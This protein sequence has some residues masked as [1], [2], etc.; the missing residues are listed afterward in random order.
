MPQVKFLRGEYNNLK[1]VPLSDGTIYFTED[2]RRLYIDTATARL[3]VAGDTIC[4]KVF[5]VLL[6]KNAWSNSKQIITKYYETKD[7]DSDNLSEILTDESIIF[8]GHSTFGTSSEEGIYPA[9]I[10]T[11]SN[12]ESITFQLYQVPATEEGTSITT[13]IPKEDIWIQIYC[14]NPLIK[15]F[16]KIEVFRTVYTTRLYLKANW[17]EPYLDTNKYYQ[18]IHVPNIAFSQMPYMLNLSDDSLENRKEYLEMTV[19]EFNCEEHPLKGDT[20][21]FFSEEKISFNIAVD[22][23][24]MLAEGDSES[25]QANNQ[26]IK[27]HVG[28]Q[29]LSGN[30]IDITTNK[31]LA[32]VPEGEERDFLVFVTE[33]NPGY[34][35]VEEVTYPREG[36]IRFTFKNGVTSV[37]SDFDCYIIQLN[38]IST[39]YIAT[40]KGGERVIDFTNTPDGWYKETRLVD[41]TD[42]GI[43]EKIEKTYYWQI[44]PDPDDEIRLSLQHLPIIY[45]VSKERATDFAKIVETKIFN[46]QIQFWSTS[47][48]EEDL[49]IVIIDWI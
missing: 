13:Q 49:D 3:P 1:K 8:I 29:P 40:L 12:A 22:L 48:I 2:T 36:T 46:N 34:S 19:Q 41:K 39:K 44:W 33:K 37:K 25:A 11:E 45:P 47:L 16:E 42:Q 38:N 26:W 17:W 30:Y 5:W 14:P 23:C 18:D 43:G 10:S 20:L 28:Q 24:I 27:V 4:G 7:G 32:D 15:S 9:V 31:K 6:E 35:D 21:R